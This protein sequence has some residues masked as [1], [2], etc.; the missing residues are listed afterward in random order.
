MNN[1]PAFSQANDFVPVGRWRRFATLAMDSFVCFLLLIFIVQV[2]AGSGVTLERTPFA[3]GLV[4]VCSGILFWMYFFACEALSGQTLGK[5]CTG[6]RVVGLDNQLSQ[7]LSLQTAAL[8]SLYRFIPLEP[9]SIF[10][11]KRSIA[12]HD[13]LSNSKVIRT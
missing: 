2:L 3:R 7:R 9:L 11:S 4:L 6:T 8:R 1:I 13:S 12:W 5:L 10:L